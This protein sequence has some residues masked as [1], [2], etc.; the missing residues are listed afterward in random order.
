MAHRTDVIEALVREVARLAPQLH[1]LTL[2]EIEARL[3]KRHGGRRVY[4]RKKAA[5]AW[6]RGARIPWFGSREAYLPS[7]IAKPARRD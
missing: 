2:L 7:V 3:R 1:P 6:L 5:R 4:I